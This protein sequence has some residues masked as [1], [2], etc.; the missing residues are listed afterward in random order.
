MPSL[1]SQGFSPAVTI[2][3]P[4][5]AFHS[6]GKF[7]ALLAMQDK[8]VEQGLYV[9]MFVGPQQTICDHRLSQLVSLSPTGPNCDLFWLMAGSD[10]IASFGFIGKKE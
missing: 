1:L 5:G 2:N 4:T 9:N 7:F 3:L 6:S 10:N 8:S